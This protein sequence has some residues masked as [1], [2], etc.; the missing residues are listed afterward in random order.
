MVDAEVFPG[1]EDNCFVYNLTIKMCL[2]L[3]LKLVIILAQI[4][5]ASK[6]KSLKTV[7]LITPKNNLQISSSNIKF[8]MRT[9]F[10]SR[11]KTLEWFTKRIINLKSLPKFKTSVND[12]DNV[13]SQQ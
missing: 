10:L 3:H 11:I 4:I 1:R 2:Y 7:I 5:Y 12:L 6:F 9:L 8:G 13:Y